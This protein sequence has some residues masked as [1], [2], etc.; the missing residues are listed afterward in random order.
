MSEIESVQGKYIITQGVRAGLF[1][2]M[3]SQTI[4]DRDAFDSVSNRQL[5]NFLISKQAA[6]LAFLIVRDCA[7]IR[8]DGGVVMNHTHHS[9]GAEHE[10]YFEP[11]ERKKLAQSTGSVL[12][13]HLSDEQKIKPFLDSWGNGLIG[14]LYAP[15]DIYFVTNP[16]QA[17]AVISLTS[18]GAC[19]GCVL[20]E[21]CHGT[22]L[23]IL[24]QSLPDVNPD[25]VLEI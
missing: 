13:A 18:M 15:K 22:A 6:V 12:A 19:N 14:N 17:L 3:G 5:L 25:N 21:D 2:R 1:Q 23:N 8:T 20:R 9:E 10:T 16:M 24:K 11:R 7:A 4:I